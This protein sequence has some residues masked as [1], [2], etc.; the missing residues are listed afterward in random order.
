MAIKNWK[1]RELLMD[2]SSMYDGSNH[3]SDIDLF[4][5][6]K[7]AG[8]RDVLIVGEIKNI[9]GT[10]KNGQRRLLERFVEKYNGTAIILYITH[11]KKVENGDTVVNIAN[12]RVE[13]YYY[14]TA[15]KKGRWV[16]PKDWLTVKEVID[17]YRG[18]E[19]GRY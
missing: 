6:G 13:E 18:G 17:T 2:F 11:N 4:Y 15:D 8:G 16:T 14:R 7:D 3:P 19:D 9:N 10:L 1:E 12:C 5:I